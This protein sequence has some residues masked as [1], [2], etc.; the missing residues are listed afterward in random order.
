MGDNKQRCNLPGM[1]Y[2]LDQPPFSDVFFATQDEHY[3]VAEHYLIPSLSSGFSAIYSPDAAIK[4]TLYEGPDDK[5]HYF[6]FAP[7][8]GKSIF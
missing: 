3:K 4:A 6:S 5:P 2:L 7:A 1:A 8:H